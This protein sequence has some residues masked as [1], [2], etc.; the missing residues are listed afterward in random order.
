M[1][2]KVIKFGIGHLF[3]TGNRPGRDE[4]FHIGGMRYSEDDAPE[5]RDWILKLNNRGLNN[6]LR[7]R[8]WEKSRVHKRFR[9]GKPSWEEAGPAEITPF[10]AELDVLFLYDRENQKEWFEK[11]VFKGEI[12]KERPVIVDL[13]EMARFFLP[14][15]KKTE[16]PDIKTLIELSIPRSV[17]KASDPQLPYLVRSLGVLLQDI[18]S[19][20]RSESQAAPGQ[21]L[22][23]SLLG[24]ALTEKPPCTFQDFHDLFRVAG[25]AHRSLGGNEL[26]A[27][28]Y[29]D[30]APY[31]I[32]NADTWSDF[33]IRAIVATM[34]ASA[35]TVPKFGG[36]K[37]SEI[38]DTLK[39][40]WNTLKKYCKKIC[41]PQ[42]LS[43]NRNK[44]VIED[45][46]TYLKLLNALVADEEINIPDLVD[47]K[48]VHGT[49]D[50]LFGKPPEEIEPEKT[51]E[52]VRRRSGSKGELEGFRPREEQVKFAD[53][54]MDGINRK[55]MYAIEAGTGTGKTLGYLAPACEF[56]RQ[57][58]DRVINDTLCLMRKRMKQDE[59]EENQDNPIIPD[60]N[61]KVIVAT[62]KRNLQD[63]LL[64]K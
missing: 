7:N 56:A 32:E 31:L 11:I 14:D 28:P 62:D 61:V 10:F 45:Q 30:K 1:P 21:S 50:R 46:E 38:A 60:A 25:I 55:G 29:G 40:S 17:W 49:F 43:G 57:T 33:L 15:G 48:F 36:V 9:E 26:F 22:I 37:L 64:E 42:T 63:Q 24:K 54:C 27:K 53:F 16:A 20:I 2:E 52:R 44:A 59:S 47:P 39:I 12:Y 3:A 5:L 35:R 13:L 19:R 58:Q 18:V 23:Y 4:I 41:P 8:L 34:P 51:A 6:S